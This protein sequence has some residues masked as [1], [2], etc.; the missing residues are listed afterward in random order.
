MPVV[1][2]VGG[3]LTSREVALLNLVSAEIAHSDKTAVDE[4]VEDYHH[5]G[6][7]KGHILANIEYAIGAS[8]EVFDTYLLTAESLHSLDVA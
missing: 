1:K 3:D 7:V 8:V 5:S 4:E 6:V 2:H